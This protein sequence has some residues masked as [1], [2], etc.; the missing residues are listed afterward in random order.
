MKTY[1]NFQIWVTDELLKV[2]ITVTDKYLSFG[3]NKKEI[4]VYDSS[5]DLTSFD[6]RA[7]DWAMRLFGYYKERSVVLTL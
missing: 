6:P 5:S 3:L 4:E 7:L 2:G 1:S